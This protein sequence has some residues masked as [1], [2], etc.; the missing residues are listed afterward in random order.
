V[1]LLADLETDRGGAG[2]LADQGGLAGAQAYG[3]NIAIGQRTEVGGS[4]IRSGN[5]CAW[6]VPANPTLIARLIRAR[7][8]NRKTD[9]IIVDIT[10]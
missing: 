7:D 1:T 9:R 5:G 4:T 3:I 6:A 10:P 2:T 8:R